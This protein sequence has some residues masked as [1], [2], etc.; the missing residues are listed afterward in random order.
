MFRRRR[1]RFYRM[2]TR[3]QLEFQNN[4]VCRIQ[5]ARFGIQVPTPHISDNF[6]KE[7]WGWGLAWVPA[8]FGV[9]G[10]SGSCSVHGPRIPNC[11]CLDPAALDPEPGLLDPNILMSFWI[12]TP[13]FWIQTL[14]VFLDPD[15]VLYCS[16]TAASVK[17]PMG[18]QWACR[19]VLLISTLLILL[20]ILIC[21]VY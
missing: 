20:L 3:N 7:F 6:G 13:A 9:C 17:T 4:M 11:I 16:S 18:E 12:P 14:F 21:L 8:W 10:C 1:R 5:E 15:S 2:S 19:S